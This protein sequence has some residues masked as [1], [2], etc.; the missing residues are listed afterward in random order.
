MHVIK[1]IVESLKFKIF[2]IK[3]ILVLLCFECMP[4]Q[5]K[6]LLVILN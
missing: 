5:K 2:N 1:E 3:A 6:I 4:M